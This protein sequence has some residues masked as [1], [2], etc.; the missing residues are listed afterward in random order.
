MTIGSSVFTTEDGGVSSYVLYGATLF[1]IFFL[2]YL[3]IS[4]NKY[5]IPPHFV[6][7]AKR[8][9]GSEAAVSS[10]RGKRKHMEDTFKAEGDLFNDGETS[11]YAVFDGH[12]GSK[13]AAFAAN[14]LHIDIKNELSPLRCKSGFQKSDSS[15]ISSA[16]STG[17]QNVD[18]QFLKNAREHGWPDGTTAVAAL[19]LGRKA[20]DREDNSTKPSSKSSAHLYVANT[21]D[22]RCILIRNGQAVPLS[23]DHKPNRVD[24]R[25]RIEASGGRVVHFGTWRVEGVLAVGRAIGDQYL[26]KWVIPDPEIRHHELTNEDVALVLATDGVWDVLSNQEVADI[27]TAKLNRSGGT[28]KQKL[29]ILARCITKKAYDSGSVDNI[30][31]LVVDLTAFTQ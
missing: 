9:Q 7:E 15:D 17:F 20:T 24:E 26:K 4:S 18:S 27:C 14:R 6:I 29:D 28:M 2:T 10:I 8:Y 30:T 25:A 1:L 22:S 11:F 19:V 31:T 16:I 5:S 13:A 3:W 21:G 23:E 12:A